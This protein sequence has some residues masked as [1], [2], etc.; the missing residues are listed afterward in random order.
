MAKNTVFGSIAKGSVSKIQ[1]AASV[2]PVNRLTPDT[3]GDSMAAISN[4]NRAAA[5]ADA[6]TA[7][8]DTANSPIKTEQVNTE[9]SSSLGVT[10]VGEDIAA[11]VVDAYELMFNQCS[12]TDKDIRGRS[13]AGPKPLSNVKSGCGESDDF[14]A[15]GPEPKVPVKGGGWL[16]PAIVGKIA[17]SVTRN[18]KNT[19]QAIADGVVSSAAGIRNLV[20]NMEVGLSLDQS[21]V[22]LTVP[23]SRE[24][25][26]ALSKLAKAAGK[27]GNVNFLS[28][29]NQRVPASQLSSIAKSNSG[30]IFKSGLSEGRGESLT[31]LNTV[32]PT[33][34]DDIM[35]GDIDSAPVTGLTD[36]QALGVTRA[37]TVPNFGDVV[38]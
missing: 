8:T 32:L 6:N 2:T 23:Q 27:K 14:F 37:T 18:M 16:T 11:P 9:T 25:D 10:E 7:L 3:S 38:G 13:T 1:N 17:A 15:C 36:A 35:P 33:W 19:V 31:S 26:A 34:E 30:P 29:L 28:K 20:C 24:T 21:G 5:I 4:T 12:L 22:A